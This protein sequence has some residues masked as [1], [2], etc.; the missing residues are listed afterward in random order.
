MTTYKHL[1]A[2]LSEGATVIHLIDLKLLDRETIQGTQDELVEYVNSYRPERLIIDF[3]DVK[4]ISSEFIAALIRCREYVKSNEGQLRLSGMNPVVRMA[5]K[6]TNLDGRL[7]F[8]YDTIPL[9]V[10]SFET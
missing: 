1:R 7:L 2:T 5:F 4:A 10:D 6:V 3:K 9:A 8:I